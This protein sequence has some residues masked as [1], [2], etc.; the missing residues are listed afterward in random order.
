[1]CHLRPT[2]VDVVGLS[3]GIE[4]AVG[5]AHSCAVLAGGTVKCW[6]RNDAGQLGDG[7]TTNRSTPVDVP[8]IEP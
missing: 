7:T 6:G 1:M 5:L 3:G 4:I 8:G 2:P